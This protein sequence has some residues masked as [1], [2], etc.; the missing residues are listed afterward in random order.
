M[1]VLAIIVQN[2]RGENLFVVTASVF[3]S[4]IAYEYSKIIYDIIIQKFSIK[5]Q[6]ISIFSSHFNRKK[7][8]N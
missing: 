8:K 6:P 2:K 5:F 7:P 3:P 1:R 4:E